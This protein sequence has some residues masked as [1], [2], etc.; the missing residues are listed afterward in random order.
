MIPEKYKSIIDLP[1]HVSPD[2]IPMSMHNRAAQFA[3]FAALTGYDDGIREAGRE[4]EARR[5]LNE[6]EKNDLDIKM[7][8]IEDIIASRP[9]ITAGYFVPDEKKA[10]GRYEQFTGNVRRL[11]RVNGELIFTD[12]SKLSL[13]DIYSVEVNG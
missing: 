11:D 1:H 10:G 9:V 3:P 5:E 6:N 7:C 8:F 4:T 2:R 13:D 12:G